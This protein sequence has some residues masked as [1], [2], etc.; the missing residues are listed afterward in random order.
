MSM[1]KMIIIIIA[2]ATM[3]SNSNAQKPT[4][5]HLAILTVN[6]EKSAAFYRDIIGLDT[7][8]NPFRDNRHT[9]FSIGASQELHI[10]AGATSIE[11]R[12]LGNHLCLSVPSVE[13]FIPILTK[14]NISYQN[15]TGE[16]NQITIRPDGVKQIYFTD[17]DGHW[18][19]IND[20]RKK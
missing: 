5:D 17:P 12:P 18:I 2:L 13:E 15:A 1:K 3:S 14:A 16:K 11:V 9:W 10:I 6:L 19:E 7:I 4:F 8:P 20:A